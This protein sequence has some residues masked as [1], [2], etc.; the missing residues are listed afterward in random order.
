[1]P[2]F[3]FF[4]A[5]LRTLY[6]LIQVF[7]FVPPFFL[8]CAFLRRQ[9]SCLSGFSTMIFLNRTS[10]FGVRSCTCTPSSRVIVVLVIRDQGLTPIFFLPIL[11][12][13]SNFFFLATFDTFWTCFFVGSGYTHQMTVF[14]FKII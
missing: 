10:F 7:I 13:F 5:L 6:S 8:F 11:T 1:M 4:Y 14:C 2:P 3:S 9:H 12:Y